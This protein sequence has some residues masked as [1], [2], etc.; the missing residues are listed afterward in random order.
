MEKE[1]IKEAEKTSGSNFL[2]YM[3]RMDYSFRHSS[4]GFI[5][6]FVKGPKIL[7][8]GCG[9]GVLIQSLEK[10][11]PSFE[12]EGIDLND[13]MIRQCK[14]KG[15]KA[16]CRSFYD[17][18]DTY[19][20]VLF[21]SVLHEFSS[22]AKEKE[23]FTEEPMRRALFKAHDILKENGNIIVRDGVKEDDRINATITAKTGK[24]IEAIRKYQADNPFYKNQ[25]LT[26]NGF[27]ITTNKRFLKE[28]LYTYTWG[29]ESYSREVN[30]VFGILMI[31]E[32]IDLVKSCGFEIANIMISAEEYKKYLEESFD[33]SSDKENIMQNAT[34]LINAVR[35]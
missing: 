25:T 13:T 16:Y 23:R 11:F 34:I 2:T 29:E 32:W 7:D 26:V 31:D 12:I 19:D 15:L 4:K 6:M 10:M 35:K 14:E 8:V 27:D 18:D 22:Y 5:P 33:F 28:F 30:E 21:S 24:Q 1:E 3:S 9:T 17:V 20:T